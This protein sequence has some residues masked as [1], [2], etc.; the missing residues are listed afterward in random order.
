VSVRVVLLVAMCVAVGSN[1]GVT[2]AY[3]LPK[4]TGAINDNCGKIH[5]LTRNG[6]EIIEGGKADL[7]QYYV[8]G[9]INR[10]QYRAGLRAVDRRLAR[11]NTADCRPPSLTP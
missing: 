6:A 1:I 4:I 5:A 2:T 8:A 10:E 7:R 11:W 3:V 9:T